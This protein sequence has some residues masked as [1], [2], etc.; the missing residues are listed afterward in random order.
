MDIDFDFKMLFVVSVC[1]ETDLMAAGVALLIID[2]GVHVVTFEE[3][4]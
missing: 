1:D 3:V 2:E 4:L